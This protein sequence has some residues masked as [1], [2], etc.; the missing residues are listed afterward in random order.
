MN[1]LNR[2]QI[3]LVHL[4]VERGIGER[5]IFN[6]FLVFPDL[7]PESDDYRYRTILLALRKIGAVKIDFAIGGLAY[8]L[9][10][11][12]ELPPPPPEAP[13]SPFLPDF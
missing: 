7:D 10:A 1:D 13:R 6:P 4:L 3:D 9:P 12:P 8:Y 2:E 11:I 5:Q